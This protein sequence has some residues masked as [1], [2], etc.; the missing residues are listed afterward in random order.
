MTWC[1]LKFLP[2]SSC[3]IAHLLLYFTGC[4]GPHAAFFAINEE[5][6]PVR[7]MPG[8]IVGK[9]WLVGVAQSL[10][11][12]SV[13]TCLCVHVLRRDKDGRPTYR[14]CLQPREQ[15]IKREKA[16]SNICTAQVHSTADGTLLPSLA[17]WV[18]PLATLGHAT[19]IDILVVGICTCF[20]LKLSS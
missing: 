20:P 17:G 7:H 14:L 5:Q 9:T 19:R 6:L 3:P 8:R 13:L 2:V 11:W 16:T 10:K 18:P 4:G 1:K 15:H 12:G